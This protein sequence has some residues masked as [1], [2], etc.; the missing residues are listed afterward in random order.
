MDPVVSAASVLV[1]LIESNYKDDKLVREHLIIMKSMRQSRIKLS[2]FNTKTSTSIILT[3]MQSFK[4][5]YTLI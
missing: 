1:W 2:S 5:D 4:L 3:Q